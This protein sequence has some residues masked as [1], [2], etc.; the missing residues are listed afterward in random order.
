MTKVWCAEINCAYC[1]SN[2]CRA[3]EV[4]FTAGNIHTKNQ[5]YI[6]HWECRTY[7]MSREAEELFK[8]LEKYN[9][10]PKESEVEDG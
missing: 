4:N 5:G 6:Q 1:I 9:N 10:K 8:V 7:Q 3:K 2:V